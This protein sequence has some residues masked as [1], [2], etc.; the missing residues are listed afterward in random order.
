MQLA[1]KGIYIDTAF[2]GGGEEGEHI[3]LIVGDKPNAIFHL[4][5]AQARAL[6]TTLIQQVHRAEVTSSMRTCLITSG[7]TRRTQVA[8]SGC[9]CTTQQANA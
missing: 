2:S 8:M 6:A 5:L 4:S 3:K 7:F 9:S 1:E